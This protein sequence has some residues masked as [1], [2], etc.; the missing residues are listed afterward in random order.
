M[1]K[2]IMAVTLC[3]AMVSTFAVGCGQK[4]ETDSG[5][6]EEKSSGK[7]EIEFVQV[8]REA[9]ESYTKV[10]E[11]FEKENPDIV[12]K[13]NVVPDAQEVLMT[14][15]SSD[16]LP[17]MMNHWPTDAQF[18][19]FEDEGL[20]LDLSEKDYMKN[21]DSKYLDAVKA[22]DGKNYIA[23]YNVNF[24][25]VYY[26]KDKFEE[27]GYTMPTKWDELIALAEE[28][29]AKGETP[30]ILPNKD[31]WTVSNLWSNIEARDLGSHEDEF[32]K[33][34]AGE[35]SFETIPEYKS[36]V[37]KMIQLL[38]YANEDSLALGYDQA[39]ND[40][41]NGEGWM[42]LQGS[43]T[44]P[45]FLSANPDFNVEFTILPNDNGKPIATQ[46]VDTGFCVNAKVADEPEKMEAIDKFLS[47]AL[48]AEGAQIY[49]DND[50]SPSC[51]S[52]NPQ[53]GYL[54][55]IF[56]HNFDFL[57]GIK[58]YTERTDGVEFVV[59]TYKENTVK[60]FIQCV[61]EAAFR[62]RMYTPGNEHPFD[63]SI[64]QLEGQ[65]GVNI[66]ENEEFISISKKHLFLL[67]Y[68]W[69]IL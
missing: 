5:K 57:T 61:G 31:S 11:A 50:K 9:A 33:M 58:S 64:Y 24:M 10:I 55:T 13:Q 69:I 32:E 23:P 52:Y 7:V 25:G 54:Q 47:F 2:K 48:S 37:E 49:T 45:S 17:D 12:I 65:N 36:S 51:V 46:A 22:K 8:K 44:L 26:N 21:I 6:S 67:E 29:K 4:N 38:D 15:A 19:Q 40:F 35:E 28:I 1:K 43:W 20:L 14:R 18:V 41:A 53:L 60:V 68:I 30:F 62:F 39:I 27:A 3:L 16:S 42:F 66:T 34:K 59:D 63:N 56:H